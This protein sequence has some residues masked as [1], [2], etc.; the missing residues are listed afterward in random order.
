MHRRP[1]AVERRL[2]WR[3]IPEPEADAP[4]V[5]GTRP[6]TCRSAEAALARGGAKYSK[7]THHTAGRSR[8][9]LTAS[10]LHLPSRPRTIGW[11]ASVMTLSLR[12]IL[13][14]VSKSSPAGIHRQRR[15]V[16][17]AVHDYVLL[18]PPMG[19]I[20]PAC[21]WATP[22]R[23]VTASRPPRRRGPASGRGPGAAR[24]CDGDRGVEDDALRSPG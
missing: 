10:P 16:G 13:Q 14:N 19:R 22:L 11:L 18:S 6:P 5:S 17:R 2:C 15:V 8:S 24:R 4:S 9:R 3:V 1:V 12:A 7:S 21:A 20:Q 23:A